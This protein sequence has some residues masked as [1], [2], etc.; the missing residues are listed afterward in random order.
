MQ[1]QPICTSLPAHGVRQD[2]YFPV[3][4]SALKQFLSLTATLDTSIWFFASFLV[5][6]KRLKPFLTSRIFEEMKKLSRRGSFG[7]VDVKVWDD[8]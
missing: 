2:L 5:K 4:S 3:H 6:G 8:S 7:V 1:R